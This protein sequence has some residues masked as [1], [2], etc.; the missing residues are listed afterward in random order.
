MNLILIRQ[1]LFTVECVGSICIIRNKIACDEILKTTLLLLE[2]PCLI[3]I[4]KKFEN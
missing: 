3:M 4:F 1:Y 2:C